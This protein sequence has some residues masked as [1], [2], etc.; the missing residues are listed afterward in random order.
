MT[1][2]KMVTVREVTDIFPIPG[3]D[4]IVAA[5]VDRGWVCVTK[6]DE[7]KVGDWGVYFEVDSFLPAEDP[8]YKFLEKDT[9]TWRNKQGI[10]LKTI[11]LKKQLSQGLLMPLHL[12]PEVKDEILCSKFFGYSPKTTP[13]LL[14]EC[15]DLDFTEVLGVEKWEADLAACLRGIARGSFP[16]FIPKT[17]EDR[18]QNL[19]RTLENRKRDYPGQ[20]YEVS[21][22]VD[23]SSCTMYLKSKEGEEPT[24]GVCSRNL[25]L[26]DSEGNAFWQMARKYNVEE[27]LRNLGGNVAIQGEVYGLGINGNWE[28]ISYIDFAAFKVWDIDDSCYLPPPERMDLLKLLDIPSVPIIGQVTLEEFASVKD[29]LAFAEGKSIFNEK[30]EGVVFKSFDGDFSFKAISNTYLLEKG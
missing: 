1:E 9:R 23:G 18:V 4:F 17:D 8:R 6:K 29:Y 21:T 20:L 16:S 27:K 13:S 3:A 12:F 5:E 26:K 7:F 24:F 15:R 11:R 28:G 14:N 25:N 19:D 2:R 30:R 22:K 10:R